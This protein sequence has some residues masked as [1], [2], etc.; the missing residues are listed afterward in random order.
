M[1][2]D[3]VSRERLR[4]VCHGC[5]I[6]IS[7]DREAVGNVRDTDGVPHLE[8]AVRFSITEGSRCELRAYKT[9]PTYESISNEKYR[10]RT[11]VD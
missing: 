2:Q 5:G 10:G 4:R 3:D 8:D 9:M 1:S 7:S 6:S 11:I